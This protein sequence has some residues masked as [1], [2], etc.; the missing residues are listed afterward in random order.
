MA[1]FS[2]KTRSS[3]SLRKRHSLVI[4]PT[5]QTRE[6]KG[7]LTMRYEEALKAKPPIAV[8]VPPPI[9]P[10][11]DVHPA[12]R[13]NCED[14]EGEKR[15]R[16]SGLANTMNSR[17]EESLAAETGVPFR[18]SVAPSEIEER[19]NSN[20]GGDSLCQDTTTNLSPTNSRL[21]SPYPGR[22]ERSDSKWR[23]KL[24]AKLADERRK[25]L[26]EKFTHILTEIPT[27]CWMEDDFMDQVAFSKR[28]SV[29]L[30]ES[31]SDDFLS[32]Q[33]EPMSQ[34]DGSNTTDTTNLSA[35]VQRESQRVRSMY[36]RRSM[37]TW[38]ERR[39]SMSLGTN[40][41]VGVGKRSN[42]LVDMN[43][44]SSSLKPGYHLTRLTVLK[45]NK[46]YH[47]GASEEIDDMDKCEV[48]RY[49]FITTIKSRSNIES[50]RLTL[51]QHGLTSGVFQSGTQTP[52]KRRGLDRVT[53]VVTTIKHVPHR[54]SSVKI[55]VSNIP[56][57]PEPLQAQPTTSERIRVA[58]NRLPGNRDKRLV[59]EAA[60]ML[61]LAP[62][63]SN[64]TEEES[65]RVVENLKR[66]EWDRSEKWRK[67]SRIIVPARGAE[68]MDYEFDIK[69]AKLIKRTWKGIPDRW[70]SVA[71]YSFLRNSARQRQDSASEEQIIESFHK[72]LHESSSDDV[73]IDVDVP[74]TISSHIM[75]RKRYQ[76][77]QRLLFRILHSF[78]LYF[79]KTGYVQGMASLAATLLC[80]YDEER[81]FIMLVRL[82]TLRG[83]DKLYE[84][85]FG[86][87][88]D[89]LEQF[90]KEW[91]SDPAI[92][93]KFEE[94]NVETTVYGTR[95]YLTIFHH[96]IPFAA[97]LRVWDVFMLLGDSEPTHNPERTNI[98]SGLSIIHATSA[99][100]IDANRETLL[101]SD[102]ENS[103][104]L[105][106]SWIPIKDEEILM[107]VTRAEWRLHLRKK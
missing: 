66:K 15:K 20:T 48:D 73:Q 14:I 45:A 31:K 26:P 35:H 100:L 71:W 106:T 77:G 104:K 76:G 37:L 1:S 78:S 58:K 92:T 38:S 64:P 52:R 13:P 34:F 102:F 16:D 3:T 29:M 101:E 89:A 86:G 17:L 11:T 2:I 99:A 30:E 7:M 74:R 40:N 59:D 80:Y 18:L 69:S 61:S 27:E 90:R 91:I 36:E 39:N 43:H 96:S 82:W 6:D 72:Y 67:M 19:L 103:M 87:L 49:G 62:K 88:I 22:L 10:P 12:L 55:P 8:T 68:G 44:A 83:M 56:H 41:L 84:P 47:Q 98:D 51:P 70:R 57:S 94:L 95:W 4:T 60:G 5:T 93:K 33:D 25:V 9:L 63:T 75:F 79:P 85:G 81:A 105:L 46:C 53:S 28:G 97:Q 21:S 24:R 54:K 32:A 23:L 50:S 107:R 42:R 65:D